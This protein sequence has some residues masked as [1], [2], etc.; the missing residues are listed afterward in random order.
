MRERWR[1]EIG[2]PPDL[3]PQ[4]EEKGGLLAPLPP[5]PV[6]LGYKSPE[7]AGS[8]II[9]PQAKPLGGPSCV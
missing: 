2:R 3:L 6:H 4:K 1:Q 5:W 8:D 7:E 9:L